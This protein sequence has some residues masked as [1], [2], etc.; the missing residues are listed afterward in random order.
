M[1][2]NS[3]V[4]R[5][6]HHKISLLKD[7]GILINILSQLD[8]THSGPKTSKH[9]PWDPPLGS[10]SRR[11]G[12]KGEDA[13]YFLQ[14]MMFREISVDPNDENV[15]WCFSLNPRDVFASNKNPSNCYG[16]YKQFCSAR[17]VRFRKVC[18]YESFIASLICDLLSERGIFRCTLLKTPNFTIAI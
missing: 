7:T 3:N 8:W 1:Q 5:H 14:V 15:S 11:K 16:T 9:P 13:K 18:N 6:L 17:G 2:T 10:Q 12:K 4:G